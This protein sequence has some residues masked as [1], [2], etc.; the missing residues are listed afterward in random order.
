MFG[1]PTGKTILLLRGE[2]SQPL[3]CKFTWHPLRGRPTAE[4]RKRARE[5]RRMAATATTAETQEA[6]LRLAGKFDVLA[7]EKDAPG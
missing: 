1:T 2:E 6:L 3:Q 7:N 4:L 5:Y